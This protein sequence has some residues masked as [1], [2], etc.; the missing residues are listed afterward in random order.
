MTSIEEGYQ[1]IFPDLFRES[2]VEKTDTVLELRYTCVEEAEIEFQVIYNMQRTLK[3]VMQDFPEIEDILLEGSLEEK[4][5][6]CQWQKDGRI[7]LCFLAE[8][9]YPQEL[10]GKTFGEEWITGVMQV[11]FSYPADDKTKYE[12]LKYEYYVIK[13]REE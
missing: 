2:V 13:N 1:I 6:R 3:E 9:Q 8:E 4:Q 7:Y 5:M 11:V 10:L 12:T